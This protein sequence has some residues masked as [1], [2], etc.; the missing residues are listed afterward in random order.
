MSR[1]TKAGLLMIVM[2]A[3]VFGFMVYKRMHQPAAAM[4][5]QGPDDS[6]ATQDATAP[7][8]TPQEKS[9]PAESDPFAAAD[10]VSSRPNRVVPAAAAQP[11]ELPDDQPARSAATSDA[12]PFAEIQ[13]PPSRAKPKLPTTI[14]DDPFEQ[15]APTVAVKPQRPVA[16]SQSST[17]AADEPS[18][19]PFA[20]ETKASKPSPAPA[21]SSDPFDEPPANSAPL[22]PPK[23]ATRFGPPDVAPREVPAKGFEE[24]QPPVKQSA[25]SDGIRAAQESDP[26]GTGS[27]LE[28]Q[29]P[30]APK[31]SE[32]EPFDAPG[33][34][35]PAVPTNPQDPGFDTDLDAKPAKSQVP[36]I[37]IPSRDNLPTTD[38]KGNDERFG[39]FRPAS[40]GQRAATVNSFPESPAPSVSET[41]VPRRAAR[42]AP[43]TQID[44][45]FATSA[46][47]PLIAGDS[48]QIEPSDN[49]WTISRKK[50]GTGRYF[51]ALAQH[52]AQVI[53]DPKRMKPGVT[54]S[55]PAA[56]ALERTYP[57]LIP[58][59]ATI[60]PVQTASVASVS[61]PAAAQAPAPVEDPEAAAGFFVANDGT[62]MYRV[63]REDTLSG[64]AQRHLGRSSRWVQV[65]ELNRD[66]LIDG[67]TLKIGTMLRLPA[68]ASR[69]D[70][71]ESPRSFR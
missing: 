11:A 60:D 53:T 52:N 21:S 51:M 8:A 29:R 57:Q 14:D 54:I 16:T 56:E 61:I 31:Q 43:I 65:Y 67:N 24:F 15:S 59:A 12:D 55:T 6:Q 66:V 70:V 42:P 47:R 37:T 39:G 18:F 36:T 10:G 9:N 13:A 35:A 2:L 64:I 62:P 45:D 26:F 69:V 58:R 7:N 48:Y 30:V 17:T 50:Y 49:Y 32:P 23:T 38:A 4:A 33:S 71:V 41:V 5:Q 46:P 27:D 40:P 19:D 20:A 28:V 25:K 1:E 34:N 63:G 22:A 3:G 44:E 68:D